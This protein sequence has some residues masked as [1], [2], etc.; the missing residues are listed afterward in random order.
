MVPNFITAALERR[1]PTIFGD[2]EQSRDF[3]YVGNVVDA[4]LLAMHAAGAT[5]STYN[6]ACGE[7]V[8]LNELV[9]VIAELTGRTIEPSY[10]DPRPGD[11]RD[12]LADI[13]RAREDL[14]YEP[15]TD[16]RAGLQRTIAW[17]EEIAGSSDA[18]DQ[19]PAETILA[20]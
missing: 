19:L 12:S 15:S 4:N 7:R 9:T 18:A 17:Y 14:G 1:P 3:T 10:A 2:G 13:T 5:G 6:I 16:L 11:V 20:P 8:S